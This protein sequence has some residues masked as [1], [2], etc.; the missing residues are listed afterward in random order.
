MTAKEYIESGTLEAYVLGALSPEEE[1]QV[2]ADVARD[3]ELATELAAIEDALLDLAHDTAV[4][5]PA[6][7]EDKIWSAL[8][9]AAPVTASVKQLEQ[10]HHFS[11]NTGNSNDGN[12]RNKTMPLGPSAGRQWRYAAMWAML[13]GSL[14]INAMLWN[15]NKE[16]KEQFASQTAKIEEVIGHQG[17]LDKAV[18]TYLKRADMMADTAIQTIVMRTMVKGHPMAATMYWDKTHGDAWVA[19]DALPEPPK[20][21]QYQLWVIQNGKPVSMG[22]MPKD[23]QGPSAVQKI[24]MKVM[25]GQAFA[26]SLEK[27]GGSPLP[28][29]ENIYVLGKS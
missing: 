12:R 9:P 17:D 19:L 26:V 3:P 7:L 24:E 5:P 23:M 18:A 15:Q 22:L 29:P 11:A 10:P 21:M 1:A 13:A 25:D 27:E 14:G 6:G 8:Q 4:P 2:R 20:G 16:Q 28:T